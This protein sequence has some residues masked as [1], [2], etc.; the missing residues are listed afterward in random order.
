MILFTFSSN[1]HYEELEIESLENRSTY[2]AP[3]CHEKAQFRAGRLVVAISV[4][5]KK[6]TVC[7]NTTTINEDYMRTTKMRAIILIK[8]DLIDDDG[9]DS[10]SEHQ[11]Q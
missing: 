7:T 3:H 6:S 2:K 9:Y 1:N 10:P 5:K 8:I 4:T 11:V